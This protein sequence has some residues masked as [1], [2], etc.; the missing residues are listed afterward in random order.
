MSR[1]AETTVQI[2]ALEYLEARYRRKA[3]RGRIFA[4]PEV[5]TKR[6]HGSKRADGL[7]AF[8][9]WLWGVYVVSLEAK[10]SKTRPAITPRIDR[11]R[12]LFNTLRAA[13]L[14]TILSGTFFFLYKLDDGFWQFILPGSVFLTAAVLYAI[15]TRNH[16]GHRTLKVVEQIEQ[17]PADERWLAFSEDAWGDFTAEQQQQLQKI[18][19]YHGIGLLLVGQGGRVERKIRARF[20]WDWW[21][22]YL[23]FYSREKEI[24]TAIR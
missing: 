16:F 21:H 6:A 2:K 11:K 3:K 10:S 12:Y 15:L 17:Y 4:Q 14:I 1:L 19:R 13:L 23:R 18:C 9:H 24:R 20:H 8:R 7:I 22:D 5:R